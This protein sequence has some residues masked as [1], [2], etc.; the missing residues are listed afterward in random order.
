MKLVFEPSGLVRTVY[1]E[2]LEL[3]ELGTVSIQRGSHVEP[4]EEGSWIV[5]LSPVGG[6][7][8]GPFRL[9]SKALAAEVTWLEEHWLAAGRVIAPNSS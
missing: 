3:S 5:D 4:N 8:L 9:R 6:P 2:T 7:R 1:A